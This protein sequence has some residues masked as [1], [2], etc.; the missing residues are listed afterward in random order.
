MAKACSKLRVQGVLARQS[1]QRPSAAQAKR[2]ADALLETASQRGTLDN[3]T[4]VVLLLQ[5]S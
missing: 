2:V 3:V 5:W 1:E 4:V